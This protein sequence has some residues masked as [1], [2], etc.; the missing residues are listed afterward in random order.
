MYSSF[1]HY[2]YFVINLSSACFARV[3]FNC[4]F[5]FDLGAFYFQG[6]FFFF[7]T[8][9]IFTKLFFHI[10][11]YLFISFI[12]IFVSSL[13]LCWCLF[14]SSLNSFSCFYTFS[15]FLSICSWN[16]LTCFYV[17]S[18]S[19]LN[20]HIIILLNLETGVSSPCLSIRSSIVWLLTFEESYFLASSISYASILRSSHVLLISW[21]EGL[22]T[23]N[24]S[25]DSIS[26]FWPDWC[27]LDCYIVSVQWSGNI[28]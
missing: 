24:L 17:S 4:I 18:L 8:F 20:I 28:T 7:K 9:Y 21:L 12:S 19:S 2:I 23:W 26:T 1:F 6:F 16:S 10:L 25:L 27:W 14:I 13:F 5:L 15:S 11:Y 3:A 22:V